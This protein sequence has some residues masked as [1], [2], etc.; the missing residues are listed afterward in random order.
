MQF[1][2]IHIFLHH[3][4]IYERFNQSIEMQ[5][6]LSQIIINLYFFY[7]LKI[8]AYLNLLREIFFFAYF[9]KKTKIKNGD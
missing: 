3:S 7:Y 5:L 6:I 8:D 4:C 1:I 2:N 9:I